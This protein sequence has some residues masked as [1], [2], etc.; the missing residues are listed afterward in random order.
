MS[1]NESVAVATDSRQR[2]CC[3]RYGLRTTNLLLLLRTQDNESAATAMDSRQRI[4][5][6]CYGLARSYHHM[7]REDFEDP[8]SS[9]N[10]LH[11]QP[12]VLAHA[13]IYL[14]ISLHMY[15]QTHTRHILC[16]LC[17]HKRISCRR[18]S[19]ADVSPRLAELARADLSL[20]ADV[21][22]AF[23]CR[24]GTC[25][26]KQKLLLLLLLPR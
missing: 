17:S 20:H 11:L 12:I 24:R 14:N 4:C 1:C 2:I 10:V 6:Y 13:D 23:P 26:D 15:I 16:T 22:A 3:Y 7:I 25:C 9:S 21:A 5:Y 18:G 19:G 8:R